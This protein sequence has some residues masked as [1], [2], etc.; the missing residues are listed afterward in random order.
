MA[1]RISQ[2]CTACNTCIPY[3]PVGAISS[4]GGKYWINPV[5]CNKCEGYFEEPQCLSLCPS[6]A[7]L[8]YQGIKGRGKSAPS[9]LSSPTLFP[10]GKSNPFASSIVIWEACNFLA[11]RDSLPLDYTDGMIHYQKSVSKNQGFITLSRPAQSTSWTGDSSCPPSLGSCLESLDLR[12]ACLNLILAAYATGAEKPWEQPFTFT[13]RHLESYLGLDKRKDLSKVARLTL[14]KSLMDQVS[15]ITTTIHWPQQ[16]KV[17]GFAV[18]QEPLW[19]ILKEEHHFREDE[20]GCHHWVG[21]TW[22]VQAGEW[23]RYFLN[24]QGCQ[25]REAFYQYGI[26]PL[27]LLTTVMSHWQHHEGAVRILLWLIFKARMGGKQRITVPMLMKVAYGE[28]RVRHTSAHKQERKRLI[29]A[30]ES[31]LEMLNHYGTTPIFDD[32][33]YPPILRPLWARLEDV[34][35]DGDDALEFWLEDSCSGSPLT[36]AGPRGK[37][38]LLMQARIQGFQLPSDWLR[39]ARG[40]TKTT[41]EPKSQRGRPTVTS[42]PTALDLTGSEISQA[43]QD[44]GMS[45]RELARRTG[46]SQSWIRDVENERFQIRVADQ[47]VL[48]RILKIEQP[49]VS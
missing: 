21:M 33:T 9:T 18:Q 19:Q 42:P 12:A 32:E 23:S 26:L 43:R 4:D 15:L 25:Q 37:W 5:L 30:F 36:A 10:D 45:Q 11:Q 22:M 3:C 28:Q 27:S 34:P 48:R 41:P 14:L 20:L 29:R 49:Q 35:E 44:L 24:R 17:Q 46:K 40:S 8:P 6:S 1:Y 31:D 13:D 47:R 38:N 7:L 2:D 39:S 16:G